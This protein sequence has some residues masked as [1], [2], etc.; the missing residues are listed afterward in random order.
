[1]N[2]EILKWIDQKRYEAKN[3]DNLAKGLVKTCGLGM[4]EGIMD[5]LVIFGP[6]LIIDGIITKKRIN[7]K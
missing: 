5:G 3:S 1:M 4:L 7:R 2:R 6:L